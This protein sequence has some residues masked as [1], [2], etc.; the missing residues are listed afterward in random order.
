MEQCSKQR[1]KLIKE[2]MQLRSCKIMI[3]SFNF[4]VF[5]S[6]LF[7]VFKYLY[8]RSN[9]FEANESPKH[10]WAQINCT[11]EAK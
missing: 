5:Q 11:F 1:V 10:N 4:K 2:I 8:F 6:Q 7:D 3:P 9:A